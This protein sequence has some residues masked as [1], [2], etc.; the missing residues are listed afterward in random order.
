MAFVFQSKRKAITDEKKDI[1]LGPGSYI[2]PQEYIAK[3]N[4]APFNSTT[5]KNSN[6]IEKEKT[7]MKNSSLNNSLEF[8]SKEKVLAH[9][10]DENVKVVEAPKMSSVFKSQSKRFKREE[11]NDVPG[12]G[13]YQIKS[14]INFSSN[15]HSRLQEPNTN[16]IFD[17]FDNYKKVPSIPGKLQGMG[18]NDEETGILE[19]NPIT[20][21]YTGN[22]MD[23][24]GPG[25]YETRGAFDQKKV[26]L[27]LQYRD[28]HLEF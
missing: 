12:P 27:F 10:V 17:V 19:L 6:K 9:F 24:V 4:Y 20:M 23:S 2:G 25:E 22:L 11:F 15:P 1:Q 26:A 13:S 5:E 18:Y 7:I 16:I 21:N 8:S 28:H 14:S 3:I